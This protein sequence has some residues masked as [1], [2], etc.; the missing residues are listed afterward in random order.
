[1]LLNG[2]AIVLHPREVRIGMLGALPDVVLRAHVP[3]IAEVV[4]FIATQAEWL[5]TRT[6]IDVIDMRCVARELAVE[7]RSVE[8]LAIDQVQNHCANARAVDVLSGQLY[9]PPVPGEECLDFFERK[10]AL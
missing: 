1:M 9:V 2:N 10:G 7:Q 3:K 8:L 4:N 5:E 6:W